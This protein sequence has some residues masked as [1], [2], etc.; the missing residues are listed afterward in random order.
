MQILFRDGPDY[1]SVTRVT[2]D[3]RNG[4]ATGR[5]VA[6]IRKADSSLVLIEEV[7]DEEKK[8]IDHYVAA[9]ARKAAVYN[10]NCFLN[11]DEYVRCALDHY[12]QIGASSEKIAAQTLLGD[13]AARMRR[14]VQ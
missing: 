4:R 1:I 3:D 10:E 9:L 7:S 8:Q 5:N 6:R 11:L 2:P 12:A 13:L 14:V